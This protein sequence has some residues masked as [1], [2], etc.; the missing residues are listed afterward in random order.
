MKEPAEINS[1]LIKEELFKDWKKL[2]P[3]SFLS[4]FFAVLPS[5][6]FMSLS[7]DNWELGFFD[8]E[9]KKITVFNRSN[10]NWVI[11]PADDVF[12]KETDSL[13]ELK[14]QEIKLKTEEAFARFQEESKNA[15]PKEVCGQGF[16]ILQKWNGSTVWNFTFITRTLKFANLKI[17]ANDGSLFEQNLIDLVDK[18]T[19]V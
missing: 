11:K 3:N 9:S 7:E 10:K 13:E 19:G 5:I 16:L 2:H 15:F 6:D 1:E 17:N 18:K 8:P 12:K 14:L 4:H